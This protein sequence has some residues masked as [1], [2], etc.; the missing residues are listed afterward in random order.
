MEAVSVALEDPNIK[1]E[2]S[3]R[4]E[5]RIEREDGGSAAGGQDYGDKANLNRMEID[6]K[7]KI[8]RLQ[9]YDER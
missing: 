6:G 3:E 1:R 5:Q 4:H 8:S 9:E 2:E 7:N